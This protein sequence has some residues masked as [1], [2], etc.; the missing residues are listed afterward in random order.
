MLDWEDEK[1]IIYLAGFFDGEGY[2]GVRTSKG[3]RNS[4]RVCLSNTH[5]GVLLLIKSRLLLYGISSC[6]G[7]TV[8]QKPGNRQRQWYLEVSGINNVNEICKMMQPYLIVKHEQA[9]LLSRF[10]FLRIVEGKTGTAFKAE[11]NQI[12]LKLKALNKRGK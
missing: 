5:Q 7:E 2:F 8:R 1:F 11:E 12:Y 6:M 9:E 4:A 3:H 10:T